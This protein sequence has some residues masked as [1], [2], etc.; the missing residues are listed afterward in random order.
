LLFGQI[1]LSTDNKEIS[2]LTDEDWTLNTD[3]KIRFSVPA[4][5]LPINPYGEVIFD[6]TDFFVLG[7]NIDPVEAIQSVFGNVGLG[8]DLGLQYTLSDK[9]TLSGSLIDLAGIRWSSNA[10]T[11]RQN[12]SYVYS[13]IEINPGDTSGVTENFL[14][15]LKTE[16]AFTTDVNPYYTMLPVKLYV[17]G[18]Y[19]IIDSNNWEFTTDKL[20]WATCVQDQV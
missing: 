2:L 13:G 14:D 10:M 5:T 15:S 16:F 19:Q 11:I 17:G 1:N 3:M 6:S 20:L 9:I 7:V 8:L 18:A 12:G 4:F